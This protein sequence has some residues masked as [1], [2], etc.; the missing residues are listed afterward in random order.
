VFWL[1]ISEIFPLGVRSKAM[2]VSTV[3]NWAANFLVAATFLSLSKAITRQGIFFLYGAIGVAAV[4]VFATKVPETRDRTL[5]DI[6]GDLVGSD[7]SRRGS[8]GGTPA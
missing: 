1:L 8:P 6:Q 7:A 2:S 3:A 4:I 5:E